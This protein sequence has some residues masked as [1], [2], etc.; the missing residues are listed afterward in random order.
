[1]L[2]DRQPELADFLRD[3]GIAPLT[4]EEREV[5]A[6]FRNRFPAQT[7]GVEQVVEA[8]KKL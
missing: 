8:I 7:D 1:V 5:L 4:P 2:E 3:Q 6:A